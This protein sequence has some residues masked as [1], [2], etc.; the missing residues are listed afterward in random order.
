[1]LV[2]C[3]V[4]HRGGFVQLADF[5]QAPEI[6]YAGEQ[7]NNLDRAFVSGAQTCQLAVN[8]VKTKL[9]VIN[10]HQLTRVFKN[11]LAAQLAANTAARTRHQ[12]YIARQVARQQ[13]S[14][15]RH[16]RAAQQI[17]YIQFLKV[18]ERHAPR[19]QIKHTRQRAHMHRKA[20]KAG[21]DFI[22][23]CAAQRRHSQ[24]NVSYAKA[25]NGAGHVA[26]RHDVDAIDAAP[27]LG[28]VVINKTQQ[29][30]PMTHTQCGGGLHARLASAVNKQAAF[31]VARLA[32]LTSQPEPGNSTA[33]AY[34]E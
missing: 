6:A 10:Q 1:M 18:L 30:K 8:A 13:R 7:R 22:A 29:N 20:A 24:Q 16:R 4:I 3:C 9:T 23:L 33:C 19:R 14:I 28:C 17:F 27:N 12:H 15:R 2:G 11:D 34:Q 5:F 31:G 25:F 21:D 26:W 32:G